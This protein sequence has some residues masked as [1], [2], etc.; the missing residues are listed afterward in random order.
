M[1]ALL[2]KVVGFF[3]NGLN[4]LEIQHFFFLSPLLLHGFDVMEFFL[5]VNEQFTCMD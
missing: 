1:L 2:D 4:K 3:R 5:Y